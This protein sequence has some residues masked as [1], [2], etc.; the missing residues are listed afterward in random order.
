MSGDSGGQRPGL[1]RRLAVWGLRLLGVLLLAFVLSQVNWRDSAHLADGTVLVGEIVGDVPADWTPEST[2]SFR[3]ADA[4][5]DSAPRVLGA[6]ELS[7]ETIGDR[8]VP[9][10]DEGL[11]HI[12]GRADKLLL[13]LGVLAFGL[14]SQF[15]VWRWWL[16]LRDQGI[17][18][19]YREAHRLTFIG[20]FFNNVVP[21]ATGGD[22]VK[23]VYVARQTSKRAEAAIT[24]LMDRVVGIVALALIAAIVLSTRLGQPE[25]RELALF[26]YGFLGCF[27]LACT[28]FFSRRLRRVL[29]VDAITARLPFAALIRRLDDAVFLYRYQKRRVLLALLLS[30]GNQLSIQFIMV[31][32]AHALHMT[33]R[34]GA[35]VPVS[36]HMIVL[37]AAWIV[38]ALPSLPGAWGV[39]EAAFAV[40]FHLV[41]V[42]RSP[43]VALSVM[44][45]MN[46]L[47]WSLLGGVYT[48]LDRS[49]VRAVTASARDEAQA[50][51]DSLPHPAGAPAPGAASDPD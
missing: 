7:T 49:T 39:R 13:V 36:D 40:G 23:A 31:L 27:A 14:S 28:V 15:G 37:P 22:L 43:A 46:Q 26:I 18:I 47:V 4:P 38:T 34:S 45:G 44:G 33:T 9:V 50:S 8:A 32:F 41:G 19:P 25:Y 21:G 6:A 10:L 1:V 12:V 35:P 2:V 24:V 42:D 48:I 20:F 5:P 16:L 3:T 30:F 17:R 11:I 29:R 51:P